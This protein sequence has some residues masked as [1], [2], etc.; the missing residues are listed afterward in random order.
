MVG[1]IAV[2]FGGS[3]FRW[4]KTTEERNALWQARHDVLYA[5]FALRPG[6]MVWATDVCV[7]ISR[8]AECL[9]ETKREI[10]ES[11]LLAP[12]V[13]HAGDGNFHVGFLLEPGNDEELARAKRVNDNMID[14]A[15]AMGG[16]CTGEHGIGVGKI[17][18]MEAEHG[19]SV[20]VMRTI[21][22]AMDPQNLMN[23]G[24]VLNL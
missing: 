5:C 7:P 4:T 8:L 18:Y 1:E 16:T 12:I 24:K 20:D 10:D 13:G 17:S 22:R 9:L 15:L 3:D 14:R 21:K 11:G 19:D 2:D 6:S 23:P